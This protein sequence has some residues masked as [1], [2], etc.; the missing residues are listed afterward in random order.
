MKKRHGL[1]VAALVL[2]S[3]F[4]YLTASAGEI[5]DLT[6]KWTGS[7]SG[8]METSVGMEIT[9]Q[10]GTAVFGSIDLDGFGGHPVEGE[11]KADGDNNFVLSIKT[12]DGKGVE[13]T[14]TTVKQNELRGSGDSFHH[15]GPV[16]LKRSE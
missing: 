1:T 9:R 3:A 5:L 16:T 2:V 15:S 8:G 7:W 10:E 6:G 12:T 11:L 4:G 14:F 13:F